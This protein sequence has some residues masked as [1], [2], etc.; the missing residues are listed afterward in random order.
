M[1]NTT[2]TIENDR[3]PLNPKLL[4][5][6]AL[7]AIVIL[8]A[9]FIFALYNSKKVAKQQPYQYSNKTTPSP[10][11][12]KLDTSGI[13]P[14]TPPG[15]EYIPGQIIVKIKPNVS[16]GQLEEAIKQYNAK[17]IDTIEQLDRY[18][19]EVPKG[20]ET[21]IMNQ[22]TKDGFVEKAEQNQVTHIFMSPNDE[23][24]KEQWALKNTGQNVG[25]KTGKADINI[26]TAWETL[27]G[28]GVKVA[29]LDTGI[30]LGHPDLQGK[31]VAQ[32][33][34]AT[35]SIDDKMGH[36]THVAGTIAA[37]TN[38]S[39]GVAGVC[40]QCQLI[41]AKTQ[42]DNGLGELP[43]VAKALTWAADQGAKV[44]NMSLGASEQ[45]SAIEDAVNYA[46]KKG[47][48]VVAA[49]GND[50]TD[51]K[52]YPAGYDNTVSVAATDITDQKASFSNYGTWVKIAAPGV[53]IMAT[54]PTHPYGF[55]EKKPGLKT[56]YDAIDGTSM[57]APIVSGVV[58]LIYGSSYGTS[59]DAVIKRLYDTAEKIPGTGTY[60]TQGRVNAGKA[61][62]GATAN[63]PGAKP[64][65]KCISQ[66][67]KCNPDG[68][69]PNKAK[70]GA[71]PASG[72]GQPTAGQPKANCDTSKYAAD[73]Q[74]NPL[75]KNFGDPNCD[76]TKDELFKL[77]KQI[78]PG[79]AN[80]WFNTIVPCESTYNPNTYAPFS[81]SPDPAGT[82][83]LYQ[84]G[85]GRNGQYDHGDVEWKIQTSN[86]VNYNK[87]IGGTFAYWGC[88]K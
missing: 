79:N 82:W 68:S 30:D 51:Q 88:N 12:L 6:L 84:M 29:I 39:I 43:P 37:N 7:A 14:T 76:F 35:D 61:L 44:I 59:A 85:R 87:K 62:E 13:V 17:I 20:Q 42:M 26:E 60:W 8:A 19:L 21:T 80:K 47:A 56:N 78:D 73:I 53:A 71:K 58:A 67:D 40:P 55:Q 65:F 81:N 34:F 41:I 45:S 2:S 66:I 77:L 10:T 9:G 3:K 5:P 74:K 18:V 25:G 28:A 70:G 1:E 83:G 38:N 46:I 36:G 16:R 4:I 72:S 33:A 23:H 32:Q 57:A 64:D 54:M 86:A 69:D 11:P 49:S 22:L 15:A 52:F 50:H 24:Y 27:Q 75:K 31:V 63:Q 48:V